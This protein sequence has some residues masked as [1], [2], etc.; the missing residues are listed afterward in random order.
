LYFW[1]QPRT[2]QS[3][4]SKT[5]HFCKE[6]AI[7]AIKI[8]NI[9]FKY[10]CSNYNILIRFTNIL[11]LH[12]TY[13]ILRNTYHHIIKATVISIIVLNDFVSLNT[14]QIPYKSQ[15]RVS[16]IKTNHHAEVSFEK[17]DSNDTRSDE[18]TEAYRN[19]R[20]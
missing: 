20:E 5:I 16:L 1:I 7:D 10:K 3:F 4:L 17:I 18:F 2:G 14:Y 12:N 6:N 11:I 9:G 19:S 8:R 15:R 13:I